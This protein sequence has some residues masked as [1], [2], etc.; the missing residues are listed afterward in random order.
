MSPDQ[1]VFI[2][3][4]CPCCNKTVSFPE[5][6]IGS[7]QDCPWCSQNIVVPEGSK[8]VA[9]EVHMSART[10]RLQLRRLGMGDRSDLLEIVSD[11][12]SLRHLRQ[13]ERRWAQDARQ[14]W[15]EARRRICRRLAHWRRL[16]E[17]CFVCTVTA[18]VPPCF[19][20]RITE[21][22]ERDVQRNTAGDSKQNGRVGAD[23][24]S[25]PH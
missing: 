4:R 17:H 12:D 20:R 13:P 19:Q 6:W 18:G 21:N 23:R 25:R 14:S 15:H 5:D 9:R 1:R 10:P 11:A 22:T 24:F 16:D 7:L 2:D 3:F 8:E